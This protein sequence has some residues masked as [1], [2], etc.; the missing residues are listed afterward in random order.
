MTDKKSKKLE[1]I[2]VGLIGAGNISQFHLQALGRIKE[3]SVEI[4]VDLDETMAENRAAE[5]DIP[6]FSSNISDLYTHK[7]DVV[8]I[9]TPPS[10]HA[11]LACEALN[12]GCHVI[13]EKP[14]ATTQEDCHRMIDTA[15]AANRHLTVNHSLLFDPFI[16]K[17]LNWV[18]AGKIGEVIAVDY[19]RSS[20]YPPFPAG[21]LPP[22]YQEGGYPFRD[23][24]IHG[25]YLIEALLGNIL[26]AKLQHWRR[27]GDP[28]LFA[29]E[30]RTQIECERGTGQMWLSWNNRPLENRLY[31]RGSLGV[32]EVDLFSMYVTCKRKLPGPQ[33]ASRILNPIFASQSTFN[34]VAW[35]VT[36][37]FR[38]KLRR[39]HGVQSFVEDFY[40]QLKQENPPTVNAEDAM[41]VTDWNERL[42]APVDH[43]KRDALKSLK[44]TIGTETLVTGG[45]GFIGSQLVK[46]LINQGEKVRLL[47][48]R[49]PKVINFENI[50]YHV[51]DLGDTEF[52]N[53]AMVGIKTVYHLGA[54]MKGAAEDFKRSTIAGT[55]NVVD[56][57]IKE[58]VENFIY[59][60]SM[61]VI[62]ALDKSKKPIDEESALETH[63]EKRGA[64]TQTKLE[65]ET[66]IQ[67]AITE[68]HLP[69]KIIRPGQV[70]GEGVPLINGAVGRKTGNHYVVFGNGKVILPLIY[71]EDLVESILLV[72]TRGSNGQLYHAIDTAHKVD[73]NTLLKLYHKDSGKTSIK[74]IPLIFIDLL[75][76][77]AE[78]LFRILGKRVPIRY[79]IRSASSSLHGPCK[80]L[81]N[82]GWKARVGVLEGIRRV[83]EA[84][85]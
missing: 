29:D 32:I 33:I 64:Y 18:D 60:S 36:K 47:V 17:A 26:D 58:S 76:F 46:K 28:Y 7:L 13:V 38:K 71:V 34:Q 10:T 62:H 66:L 35:N 37:V 5:Y 31:V 9:A 19:F 8:H 20:D 82:L 75:G 42:A 41:R 1:T 49:T 81:E 70:F 67:K 80:P 85:S 65:A 72:A 2:R 27:G 14:M 3:V 83:I 6:A 54:G 59:I 40:E 15:K 12:K 4:I 69:A 61:S 25:L 57:A 24:G 48:R 74:H 39:F 68:R 45:N 11:T 77:G 63:P 44:Y 56:A 22:Q 79:R 51:G 73:Q 50:E 78:L 53:K 21:K 52:V 55:Q 43:A 23:I 30:W 84:E 16:R